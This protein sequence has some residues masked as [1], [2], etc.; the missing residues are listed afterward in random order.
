MKSYLAKKGEVTP[1]W[2]VVDA[3]NKVLGR[4]AVEIANILRGRHR[5]TYTPPY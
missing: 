5:P 3:S 2:Y 4:L 1:N